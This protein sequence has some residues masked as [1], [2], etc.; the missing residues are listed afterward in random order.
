M[1]PTELHVWRAVLDQPQTVAQRWHDQLAPNEQ[2]RAK[3]FH[4]ERDRRRFIVAR[5]VL[6]SILA[7]YLNAL[8]AQ[9]TFDVGAYGKPSLPDQSLQFNMSHSHELAVY[10]ITL[11]QAVGIDV[12]YMLRPVADIDQLVDRFFSANESAVYHALPPD[13]KHSAFFRCWTRKEAYI[14]AIGEGLSHP[15]DR[16]DVAF[17]PDQAPAVLSIDGDQA[18]AQRWS[19]FHFESDTDY[20]GAVAI[21]GLTWQVTCRS[22]TDQPPS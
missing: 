8:P 10:A 1:T 12:E 22:W 3:R 4:F 13:E 18:A 20:V 21:P 9:L 11:N 7:T 19:L 2:A 6:R 5:G 15:L 16:F 14:K 17:A